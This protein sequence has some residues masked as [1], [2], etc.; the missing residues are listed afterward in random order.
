MTVVSARLVTVKVLPEAGLALVNAL[1]PDVLF[2]TRGR[3]R[4]HLHCLCNTTVRQLRSYVLDALSTIGVKHNKTGLTSSSRDSSRSKLPETIST[5]PQRAPRSIDTAYRRG[6][7]GVRRLLFQCASETRHLQT[8]Y[9]PYQ[10]LATERTHC[11]LLSSI[12]SF[13]TVLRSVSPNF[14]FYIFFRT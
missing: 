7:R 5:V 6:K 14:V 9:H 4:P 8:L 3:K 13:L 10:P 1:Y 12:H 11:S 2:L